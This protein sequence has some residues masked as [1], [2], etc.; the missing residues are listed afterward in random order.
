MRCLGGPFDR[1][2]LRTALWLFSPRDRNSHLPRGIVVKHKRRF[3]SVQVPQGTWR[4]PLTLQTKKLATKSSG[5]AVAN[6]RGTVAIDHRR[7]LY[8]STLDH[9]RDYENILVG[10]TAGLFRQAGW[11]WLR[12]VGRHHKAVICRYAAKK[13]YIPGSPSRTEVPYLDIRIL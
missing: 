8:K 2:T 9:R 6:H 1:L 5:V 3:F 12:S 4:E 11:G 10:K 7:V 13:V